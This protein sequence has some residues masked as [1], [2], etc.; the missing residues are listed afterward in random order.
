MTGAIATQLLGG[1]AGFC[2]VGRS[3]SLAEYRRDQPHGVERLRSAGRQLAQTPYF[4]RN[5][6]VKVL[7]AA[8]AR[9]LTR[10]LGNRSGEWPY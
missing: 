10:L 8:R 2:Y 6:A 5:L 3:G 4:A 9:P 7:I 1:G